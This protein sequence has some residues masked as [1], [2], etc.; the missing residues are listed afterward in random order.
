MAVVL[1]RLGFGRILRWRCVC[2]PTVG[3]GE[4]ELTEARNADLA[5]GVGI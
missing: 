5:E 4:F 3:N 1:S 2:S